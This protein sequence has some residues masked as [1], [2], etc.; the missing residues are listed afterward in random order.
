[1]PPLN[2]PLI[3]NQLMEFRAIKLYNRDGFEACIFKAKA[4]GL[5]GQGQ[6]H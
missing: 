3:L 1:M 6:S 2:P 5:L 4:N